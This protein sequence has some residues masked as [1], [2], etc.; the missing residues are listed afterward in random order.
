MAVLHFFLVNSSLYILFS[1]RIIE[2]ET[3][4]DT[5][6]NP[7]FRRLKF[8]IPF[9]PDPSMNIFVSSLQTALSK[10]CKSKFFKANF[11]NCNHPFT[12]PAHTPLPF[13]LVI[14]NWRY[15]PKQDC[16]GWPSSDIQMY[17]GKACWG[18]MNCCKNVGP[19]R[20]SRFDIYWIQTNKVDFIIGWSSITPKRSEIR[21]F[22]GLNLNYLSTP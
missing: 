4:F 22:N 17:T 2:I 13:Y 18:C 10:N 16:K 9:Y 20:F 8:Q 15:S 11:L 5:F 19:D 7:G 21:Q 3:I 14:V 6:R 1:M 12:I